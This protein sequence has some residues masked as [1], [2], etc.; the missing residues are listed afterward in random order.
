MQLH[1]GRFLVPTPL[2]FWVS[3]LGE[4]GVERGGGDWQKVMNRVLIPPRTCCP[5]PPTKWIIDQIAYYSN[6]QGRAY[7]LTNFTSFKFEK[8]IESYNYI[9]KM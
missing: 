5:L 6:L 1:V 9:F 2:V 4:G 8:I 7:Y 3:L